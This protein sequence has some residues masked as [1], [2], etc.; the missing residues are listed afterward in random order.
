M[1]WGCR[2]RNK[3]GQQDREGLQVVNGASDEGRQGDSEWSL[4]RSKM[5]RKGSAP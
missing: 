4:E 5:G 3:I 1:I 2:G